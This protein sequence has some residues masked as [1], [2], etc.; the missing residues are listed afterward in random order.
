MYQRSGLRLG[1][2]QCSFAVVVD[3]DVN[4][5]QLGIVRDDSFRA[6]LMNGS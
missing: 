5:L 4:H 1:R 2:D 3:V 6:V